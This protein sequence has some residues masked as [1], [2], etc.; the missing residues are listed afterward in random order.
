MSRTPAQSPTALPYREMRQ[1]RAIARTAQMEL[2]RKAE[3]LQASKA[4]VQLPW[5]LMCPC[6]WSRVGVVART[7]VSVSFAN[8][9]APAPGCRWRGSR[10]S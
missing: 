6:M 1:Y 4:Q 3:E 8:A 5:S 2:Q 9:C 10:W 7:R